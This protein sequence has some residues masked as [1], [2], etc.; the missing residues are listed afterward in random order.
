M[1]K[2]SRVGLAGLLLAAV[3]MPAAAGRKGAVVSS[4]A[5]GRSRARG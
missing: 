2:L 4:R 5:V 3:A 1:R